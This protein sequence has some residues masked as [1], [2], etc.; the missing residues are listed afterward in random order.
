MRQLKTEPKHSSSMTKRLLFFLQTFSET[1]GRIVSWLS[2]LIVLLTFAV[3]VLRYGFNLGWIAMQEV[4][5]YMY[6]WSFML[7]AAYTLKHDG[8][9]RVDIIYCHMSPRHQ[10]W[11]NLLGTLLLL[12]P[13]CGFI[14]WSSLEYVSFSWAVHEASG[15][16]GGLAWVYIL[17]TTLLVMPLLVLLQGLSIVLECWHQLSS[18]PDAK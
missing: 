9:V 5:V 17:K 8:H 18:S 6:A 2:L 7:A 14:F 13:M 4:I 12:F 10:H 3:V 15:E 11:V 16:A 1:T